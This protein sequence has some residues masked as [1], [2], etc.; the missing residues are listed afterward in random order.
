MFFCFLRNEDLNIYVQRD[1]ATVCLAR[2]TKRNR[3]WQ[4]Q[5][6]KNEE[7]KSDDHAHTHSHTH[8]LTHIKNGTRD[9]VRENGGRTMNKKSTKI[10]SCKPEDRE[11]EVED[12][13]EK[14]KEIETEREKKAKQ[15]KDSAVPMEK[16]YQECDVFLCVP[17]RM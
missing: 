7:E 17:K 1:K 6:K 4:Q 8:S 11:E 14:K 13:R 12:R 2:L 16:S 5:P 10:L 15:T 9:E 3:W